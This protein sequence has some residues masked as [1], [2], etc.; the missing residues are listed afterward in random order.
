M[1]TQF[2]VLEQDPDIA[3]YKD[4]H[5]IAG[6]LKLYFREIPAPIFPKNCYRDLLLADGKLTFDLVTF[7]K[8]I[9]EPEQ[10]LFRIK[11]IV[12]DQLP[13]QNFK[14]VQMVFALLYKVQERSSVN[15]M[16]ASNLGICW[17]PTL[18][19]SG[20][21]GTSIV[22]TLIEKYQFIFLVWKF[23]FE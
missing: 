12:L 22:Q 3:S 17:G 8:D 1:T 14:A 10:R 20:S 5:V 18:F 21:Q 23:G 19:R 9:E 7:S 13:P 6:L 16:T 4:P 2:I 11:D 15:K